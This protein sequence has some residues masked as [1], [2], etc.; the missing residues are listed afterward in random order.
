MKYR[1][2]GTEDGPDRI[3]FMR[4]VT[5]ERGG[6][7]VEVTDA[8][9]LAKLENHPLFKRGPGRPRKT[10]EDPGDGNEN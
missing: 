6:P 8:E 9:V 7:S 5:F 1:F 2:I 10:T 4:R 3:V